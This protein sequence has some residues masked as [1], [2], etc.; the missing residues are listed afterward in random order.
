MAYAVTLLLTAQLLKPNFNFSSNLSSN[1]SVWPGPIGIIYCLGVLWSYFSS[2]GPESLCSGSSSSWLSFL[3][4]APS[5]SSLISL[6][7]DFMIDS[8]P[9][10]KGVIYRHS[11]PS[12]HSGLSYSVRI[13]SCNIAVMF[14]ELTNAMY[15]IDLFPVVIFPKL[16]SDCTIST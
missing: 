4:L 16:N 8:S 5:A 13:S 2:S 6:L 10:S 15:K 7:I 1:L 14:D 3:F 9:S 12:K 11:I